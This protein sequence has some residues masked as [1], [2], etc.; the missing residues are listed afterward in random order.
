MDYTDWGDLKQFLLATRRRGFKSPQTVTAISST[1]N[2]ICQQVSVGM[3]YLAKQFIH[4]DLAARNCFNFFKFKDQ[5]Q[6]PL[7]SLDTYAQEY[8]Q[9][10]SKKSF[11]CDGFHLKL[12]LE[13]IGL[14]RMIYGLLLY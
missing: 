3:E 8:F 7:L 6:L 2:L 13:I 12:S 5:D 9:H 10:E 11:L 14:L 4:K 1:K